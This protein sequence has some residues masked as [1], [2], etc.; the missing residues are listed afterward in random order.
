M[1]IQI[2]INIKTSISINIKTNT[3]TDIKCKLHNRWTLWDLYHKYYQNNYYQALNMI[4]KINILG[5]SFW[6]LVC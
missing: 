4:K 6:A 3:K 2:Y 5:I 1:T